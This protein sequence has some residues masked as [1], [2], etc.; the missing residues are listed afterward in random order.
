MSL[1]QPPEIS[2]KKS[3]HQADYI[4]F[5]KNHWLEITCV[6]V[7]LAVFGIGYHFGHN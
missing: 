2:V 4:E 7:L 1:D 5:V 3:W 6:L